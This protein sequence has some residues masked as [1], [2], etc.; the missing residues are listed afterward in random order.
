[1]FVACL[2]PSYYLVATVVFN[3]YNFKVSYSIPE[4]MKQLI[5]CVTLFKK[6]QILK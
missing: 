1:M 4:L 3:F 6:Q 5:L 2:G